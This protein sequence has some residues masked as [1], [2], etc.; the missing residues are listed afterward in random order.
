MKSRI[1]AV[2]VLVFVHGM[3][4]W[5]WEANGRARVQEATTPGTA[6]KI[7]GAVG[8]PLTLTI[9]DLKKMPRKTLTVTNPHDRKQEVYEGVLVEELLKR[10]GVPQ[11]EHLRG[12]SLASYVVFKAEDGYRVV[13]SIA[14][15]DSGI[16]DSDVIVADTV[17]GGAISGK[18]G[19]FG[20]VAPH[21]KRPARWVRMLKE[22]TVVKPASE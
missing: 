6:L 8:A 19:P 22:I 1:A 21:D 2:A 9:D 13:F 12:Q 5:S 7:D 14:E 16:L 10:A 3:G 15:L 20:L 18:A 4:A 11:G 17:D